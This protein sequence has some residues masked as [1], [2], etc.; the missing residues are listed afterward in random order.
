MEGNA[1]ARR[2]ARCRQ[3]KPLSEFGRKRPNDLQAYC[4]PCQSEYKK[5]HYRKSKDSYLA[6]V[7]RSVT[8]LQAIL[9]AAKDKPCADCGVKYPYYVMDF[10]HRD[11]VEKRGAMTRFLK[12][13][14]REALLAEIAKCDVVCSNC[15]RERTYQRRL[16]RPKKHRK[17]EETIE[18][19]P[20][21]LL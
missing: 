20:D 17:E 21:V 16:L 18:T 15:H 12:R 2:C 4:R 3:M 5:D 13:H 9:R 1:T 11:G 14:S 8:R 19:A 6:A 7:R 10:D